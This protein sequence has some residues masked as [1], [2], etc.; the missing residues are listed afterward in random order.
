M[1]T[2][3]SKH[4]PSNCQCPEGKQRCC[5]G[6]TQ[7]ANH[8]V[9]VAS[10]VQGHHQHHV[11][12]PM[13]RPT[14]VIRQYS[15]CKR[16]TGARAFCI[17]YDVIAHCYRCCSVPATSLVA[18]YALRGLSEARG[19]DYLTAP[20]HPLCCYEFM[21]NTIA[22]SLLQPRKRR[23]IALQVQVRR[24]R[25]CTSDTIHTC[26][27]AQRCKATSL[28]RTW[29]RVVV[30]AVRFKNDRLVNYPAVYQ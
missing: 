30:M 1:C 4:I 22:R 6:R 8:H 2:C 18:Q 24:C 7:S 13:K 3:T 29:Q 28:R 15:S 25:S 26:N 9:T 27:R 19:H 16:Q 20:F 12:L 17:F 10:H 11:E 5:L 23:K 21:K 14:S